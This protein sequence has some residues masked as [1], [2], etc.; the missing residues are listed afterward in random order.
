MVT[1]TIDGQEVQAEE[2]TTVLE[3]ARGLGIDIPTLCYHPDVTPYGACRLCVVEFS[4][5]GH[6]WV[7]TSCNYPVQEGIVVKTDAP[8]AIQ[9]AASSRLLVTA[10]VWRV[11]SLSGTR[12]MGP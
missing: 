12:V 11:L 2:G 1:L 5:N 10:T 7:D 6:S 4:R 9:T 3:A 8:A